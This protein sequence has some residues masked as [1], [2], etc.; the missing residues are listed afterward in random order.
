MGM[1]VG[2]ERMIRGQLDD[3]YSKEMSMNK[4]GIRESKFMDMRQIDEDSLLV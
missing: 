4:G 3:R 1:R 2:V